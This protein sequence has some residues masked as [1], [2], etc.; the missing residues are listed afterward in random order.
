MLERNDP[1]E[2]THWLQDRE[3]SV[4]LSKGLTQHLMGMW[5]SS[6]AL[7][8]DFSGFVA[9]QAGQQLPL[10]FDHPLQDKPSS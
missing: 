5:T 1:A 8:H 9:K 4:V 2:L 6:R 3:W 10:S 7:S